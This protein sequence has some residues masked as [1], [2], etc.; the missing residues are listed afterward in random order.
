MTEEFRLIRPQIIP[1]L[2]DEFC[3]AVLANHAY[4]DSQEANGVPLVIGLERE[5]GKISRFE[6]LVFPEDHPKA[7]SNF[8][9]SERVVKFLL[10]QRGGFRVFLGGPKS[11][12]KHIKSVYSNDGK[13]HF[14]YHFMG[15]Q[16]YE[17]PFSVEIRN[18]LEIPPTNEGGESIGGHLEG[19]RIGFDLGASDR[20]VSAVVD[21]K[22][23]FSEEK[24]WNPSI[25]SDPEYHFNEIFESIKMAA[26]KLARVDAIGGSSA[27]VY[28]NNRPMVASL[29]RGIPT[30]RLNEVRDLFL[31]IQKEFRVPLVVINDGDVAAL[32]GSMSLEENGVLGI[33]L[34][35][36]EAAGFVDKEG[37]ILGWLNELAFAPIDYSPKASV[38]EWSGDSGCGSTYFSQQCVFRLA[39]KAGIDIPKD[40]PNAEKLIY[41]Q[42]KLKAGHDG[43]VKIW[44]TMGVYLGYGIAHYADF[45]D[46][47]NVIILGRCTSGE[48]GII[49]LD[50]VKEVLRTEFPELIKRINIQ[51]PD[52]KSRR[53]GQSIA[54]ASL[55][56]LDHK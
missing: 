16:V 36:S 23:I 30:N 13:R 2:D 12:G 41:A 7:V 48:G 24:I 42:E 8:H 29:F 51:L 3:P 37:H 22:V 53:V 43:A 6:T 39:P 10:W 45:Y 19:N 4:L 40:V 47:Q 26:S 31:R 21:G 32:A 5:S 9:Y 11:I 35:S 17:K 27:G 14:D 28:I 38:D 1:P 33:A 46:V 50:K 56:K 20:K 44:Q 54:A 15:D 52:E 34:G 25:Q 18:P 49:I 55:P